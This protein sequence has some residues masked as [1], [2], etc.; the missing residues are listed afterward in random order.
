[1]TIEITR[2]DKYPLYCPKCSVAGTLI[3]KIYNN[4]GVIHDGIKYK[5]SEI[6]KITIICEA[7]RTV[8]F[9][10]I[11]PTIH[12]EYSGIL[13]LQRH[14]YPNNERDEFSTKIKDRSESCRG[15]NPT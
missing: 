11:P 8:R 9:K 4:A 2:P 7:G 10:K 5:F 12:A 1:M 6:E 3:N 15:L 13:D 14:G